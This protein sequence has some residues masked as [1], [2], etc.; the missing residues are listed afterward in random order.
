MTALLMSCSP[1]EAIPPYEYHNM[2]TEVERRLGSDDLSAFGWIADLSVSQDGRLVYVLD[3]MSAEVTVWGSSGALVRRV[4]GRGEGP[5]EFGDPIAVSA[6]DDEG[7]HVLDGERYIRFAPDGSVV[8]MHSVPSSVSHR[9]FRLAPTGMTA[10]GAIIAHPLIASS[11]VAGW[12]G[13]DPI[14]TYPLLLL[15]PGEPEWRMDTLVVV[16]DRNASLSVRRSDDAVGGVH[17]NQPF[18]DSDI[19]TLDPEARTLAVTRRRGVGA[20]GLQLTK[21]SASAAADTLWSRRIELAPVRLTDAI[22]AFV[23]DVAESIVA[24][25]WPDVTPGVARRLIRESLFTPEHYPATDR[26]AHMSNGEV[27]MRS[28]EAADSDTLRVWYFVSGEEDPPT[29]VLLPEAYLPFDRRGDRVWG[30][31]YDEFNVNYVERRRLL[32]PGGVSG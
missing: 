26:V 29:R 14:R 10:E 11:I 18:S 9:G 13:D 16:D 31:S 5:G 23:E 22:Q 8:G 20:G 21:I 25:S 27:W 32:A 30:V 2:V 28:P 3:M 6:L 19:A 1:Q 15:T 4:G 12:Y 17:M 7:F 24:E